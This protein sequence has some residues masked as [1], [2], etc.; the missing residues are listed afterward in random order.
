M[1]TPQQNSVVETEHQHLLNV[2]R[3]LMFQSH[4]PMSFWGNCVLTAAHLINRTSVPLL[5][6]KTPYAAL[7]EREEDY[8]MLKT[9]GCLAYASTHA[10]SRS[11]FD[12]RVTPCVL[13]GY[14]VGVK[15][16]KLY[17]IAKNS[18]FISRD[19]LFFEELFPFHSMKDDQHVTDIES[20]FE[21]FVLP[22]SLSDIA[23]E[24]SFTAHDNRSI[25]S[26]QMVNE[27]CSNNVFD[28]NEIFSHP[29]AAD[30]NDLS[31]IPTA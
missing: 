18:F 27:Y 29:N 24:I 20:F 12:P 5:L 10:V 28:D 8:S 30:V 13:V 4:V 25:T 21:S 23:G 7:F 14:Q 31:L 6:N 19:V 1:Q 3:A 16:F 22:R 11:K 2:P 26:Q 9:F 15:G 17:I